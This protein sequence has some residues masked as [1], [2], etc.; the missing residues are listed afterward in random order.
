[1]VDSAL[2]TEGVTFGLIAA[3]PDGSSGL[4]SGRFPAV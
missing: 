4:D 1:M 3:G 2:G